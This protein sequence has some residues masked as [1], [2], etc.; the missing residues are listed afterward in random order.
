MGKVSEMFFI[1]NLH[2]MYNKT[3]LL[4]MSSE[5][6]LRG[7]PIEKAFEQKQNRLVHGTKSSDDIEIDMMIQKLKDFFSVSLAQKGG[8]LSLEKLKDK[9]RERIYQI[10]PRSV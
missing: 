8:S 1:E 2:L 7:S 3:N 6:L 9:I 4:K 10:K 5:K